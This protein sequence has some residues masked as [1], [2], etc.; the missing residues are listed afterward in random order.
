M[1][2]AKMFLIISVL[3]LSVV[4]LGCGEE[5]AGDAINRFKR[6]FTFNR[7]QTIEPATLDNTPKLTCPRTVS[8][9]ISRSGLQVET[10]DRNY[11]YNK[12]ITFCRYGCDGLRPLR[13]FR[14]TIFVA[15]HVVPIS[16]KT[17]SIFS[18]KVL[19]FNLLRNDD[20]CHSD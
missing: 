2:L 14:R 3:V 17:Y 7:P 16:I 20:M 4:V 13:R 9:C 6:S 1:R 18:Y 10:W 5:S 8:K 12:R 19:V 15:Q 11:N